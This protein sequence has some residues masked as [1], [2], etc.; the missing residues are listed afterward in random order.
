M[1]ESILGDL[2]RLRDNYNDMYNEL[3][4]LVIHVNEH[5]DDEDNDYLV[6]WSV[7][8]QARHTTDNQDIIKRIENEWEIERGNDRKK[9][10][11]FTDANE[12]GGLESK[13][14]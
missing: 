3:A 6:Q 2:K 12:E 1:T 7:K 11:D 4:R 14:T 10:E 8:N 5:P 9:R 13:E